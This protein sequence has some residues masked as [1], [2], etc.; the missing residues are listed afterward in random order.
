MWISTQTI[1]KVPYI[2][3]GE[4]VLMFSIKKSGLIFL[5]LMTLLSVFGAFVWMH[6][7]YTYVAKTYVHGYIKPTYPAIISVSVVFLC[8]FLTLILLGL[9]LFRKTVRHRI[10]LCAMLG[11]CLVFMM[12]GAGVHAVATSS[13]CESYT[14]DEESYMVLDVGV[15]QD[16][17]TAFFPSSE[18]IYEW[19]NAD[20]EI[21]Y[22]YGFCYPMFF[23]CDVYD[24]RL[25][26]DFKKQSSAFDAFLQ[27]AMSFGET[28]ILE[29]GDTVILVV[30][31]TTEICN[32]EQVFIQHQI[33]IDKANRT[34]LFSAIK[35]SILA[36]Y[37]FG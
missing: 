16:A 18:Q 32:G 29:N 14:T 19:M 17:L 33:I 15:P 34:V 24:I 9:L 25:S 20:A 8:A 30:K 11:I 3:L 36:P 22:A 27:Q 6:K 5:C 23:D 10:L 21:S 31:A 12:V 26:V 37:T 1:D 13:A 28:K 2:E 35:N 4:V 7:G